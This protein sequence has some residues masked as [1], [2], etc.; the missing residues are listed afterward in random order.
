[1][2]ESPS[3]SGSPSGSGGTGTSSLPVPATAQ[4]IDVWNSFT[5]PDGAFFNEIVKQYNADTPNCQ[6]TVQT[7]PGGEFVAK[8]EAAQSGGQPPQ[9]IAAGYDQLAGLAES[10]II[11]DIGDLATAGG[12]DAAQ[13]PQALWDA[14]EWKG[15]RYG[16]PFDT[17]P[18]V[19][20]Y[21]KKLF[22]DAGLDPETPPTDMASFEAAIKAIKDKT[23]N[24][25]YQMVSSGP[26]ANFLVGLQFAMLFYQAGGEW[27]NADFS[28]ATFNS[29][30]GV[31]AAEYL[32]KLVNELGVPKVESDAEIAAFKQGKNGMVMSGIWETSGY[33]DALK[34]DLGI[35][36]VPKIFGDGDWGGSHDFAVGASASGDQRACAYHFIDTFNKNSLAWAKAGQLPANNDVRASLEGQTEGLLPLIAKEAPLAESVRFLPNIPGGGD[37]LFAG[38]GAGEAAVFVINGKAAKETLD[39]AVT[40][41]TDVLKTN[42]ERYG[43]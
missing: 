5:G 6:V 14:G 17:H 2:S 11:S 13:F 40:F 37:L 3:A 15:T 39:A 27:T 22:K 36:P 20:F 31:K 26:G 34:D 10:K 23:G 29:D 24:D 30:A 7:Q 19:F 9:V 28:E 43:Y 42:K 33:N 41:N 21:N 4:K 38:N 12:V 25:G 18:M 16:I 32:A 1:M 35:A 8:L